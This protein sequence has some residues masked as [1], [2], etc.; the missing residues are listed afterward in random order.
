MI[1]AYCGETYYHYQGQ[2]QDVG[3]GKNHCSRTCYTADIGQIVGVTAQAI[4]RAGRMGLTQREAAATLRVSYPHFRRLVSKSGLRDLF[5]ANG[6][7]Q[8]VAGMR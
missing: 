5:P 1:C 4:A 2:G 8:F 3:K 7:A 6:R